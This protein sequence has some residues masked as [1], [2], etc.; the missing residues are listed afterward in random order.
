MYFGVGVL[1]SLLLLSNFAFFKLF[2]KYIKF[3]GPKLLC[4]QKP[5]YNFIIGSINHCIKSIKVIPFIRI[6]P[7]YVGFA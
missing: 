2:D 7:S 5:F 6:S 4:Q 1:F 3:K